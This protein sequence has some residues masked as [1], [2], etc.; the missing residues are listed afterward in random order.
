MASP[1]MVASELLLAFIQAWLLY[2]KQQGLTDREIDAAF[3][4]SFGKFMVIS[5]A[6]LTP[7]K[8]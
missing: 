6:P 8:E 2:Q 1:A 3:A 5:A 7:V 4:L